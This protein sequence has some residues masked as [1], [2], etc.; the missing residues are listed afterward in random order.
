MPLSRGQGIGPYEIL[1]L[2]G[3]GGMGEVYR[4]RDARLRRDVA[5]KFLRAETSSDPERLR[6]FEQEARAAGALNHPNVLAVHDVGTHESAP[7]LVTELLEGMTLREK[8]RSGGLTVREA[9]ECSVQ[10]ARGLSAAHERGIVHRDLKPENVFL[11]VDARGQDG[12]GGV[13]RRRSGKR[14]IRRPA[15]P[16]R[17]GGS[18]PEGQGA[19]FYQG[20]P[21]PPC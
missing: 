6:R 18:R 1:S 2:L 7:Y 4:A 15:G 17:G 20:P 8:L 13:A 16:N 12:S 14:A 3:A 5:I 11:T 9:V 10:I 21:D 19:E